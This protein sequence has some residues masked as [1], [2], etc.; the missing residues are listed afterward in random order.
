MTSPFLV[1]KKSAVDLPILFDALCSLGG[2]VAVRVAATK[3]VTSLV[4]VMVIDVVE[5]TAIASLGHMHGILNKRPQRFKSYNDAITWSLHSGTIRNPEA[6]NVSIPSQLT[7]L[8][9]GS[10]TWRTDLK[11][12]SEYWRGAC[13]VA[14]LATR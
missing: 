2:A 3:K 8:D 5:G 11:S 9:D 7:K 1:C 4:G 10:L 14:L 13:L 12:S 6:A